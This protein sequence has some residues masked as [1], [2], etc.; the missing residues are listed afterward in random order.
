LDVAIDGR[1]V[2]QYTLR[3]GR[4]FSL[5]V[6]IANLRPGVHELKVTAH[7]F[8]VVDDYLGND[9]CRPLAYWLAGLRR[10]APLLAA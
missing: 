2:R 6:P 8:V 3:D 7:A 4:P 9:D 10:E 1:P 5:A